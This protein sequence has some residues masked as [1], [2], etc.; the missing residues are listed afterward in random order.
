[1]TKHSTAHVS[2]N[3]IFS[4]FLNFLAY[5]YS[6]CS[7]P[8]FYIS[9]I[10]V[11]ISP[12]SFLILFIW[13]FSVVCQ[14]CLLFSKNQLLILLIFFPTFFPNLFFKFYFIFKLYKIILVLPNIKMNPPQVYI[15]HRLVGG[16]PFIN[17]CMYR[18]F[19]ILGDFS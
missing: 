15:K 8:V 19:S 6:W 12:F 10:S 13:V 18:V 9:V 11:I 14:F 17:Y 2:R 7:L 5:N 16:M 1:M 4:K 3:F